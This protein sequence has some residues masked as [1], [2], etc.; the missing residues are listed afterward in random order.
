M[1]NDN[2]PPINDEII[3]LIFDTLTFEFGERFTSIA[4][5]HEELEK[6][7]MAWWNVIYK[8]NK[9]A[10]LQCLDS[11][12]VGQDVNPPGPRAFRNLYQ[13][14]YRPIHEVMAEQS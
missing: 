7:K 10:V 13:S 4:K 9:K 3:S 2:L 6:M 8:M 14:Y 5:T 11:M 12:E 1:N